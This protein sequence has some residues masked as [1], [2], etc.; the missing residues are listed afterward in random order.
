MNNTNLNIEAQ[1]KIKVN[2]FNLIF[3]VANAHHSIYLK[4]LYGL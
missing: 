2:R 1:F 4:K 3:I